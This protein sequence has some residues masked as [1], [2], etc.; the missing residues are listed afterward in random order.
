MV[1][2]RKKLFNNYIKSLFRVD[3]DNIGCPI[4]IKFDD[5]ENNTYFAV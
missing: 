2:L 3:K 1:L 4:Y 5:L